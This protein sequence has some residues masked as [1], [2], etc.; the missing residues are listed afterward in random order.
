[1]D[2]HHAG[3]AVPRR[4]KRHVHPRAQAPAQPR[5]PAGV[6][7]LSLIR[8]RREQELEQRIDYRH[9][10]RPGSDNDHDQDNKEQAG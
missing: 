2:G 9:L 3:L 5:Q 6:D 4:I 10:P 1:M 7:Y 8:K